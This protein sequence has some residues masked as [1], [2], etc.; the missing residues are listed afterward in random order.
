MERI[1]LLRLIRVLFYASAIVVFIVGCGC[2]DDD[3][4]AEDDASADRSDS[5]GTSGSGGIDGGGGESGT[6]SSMDSGAPDGA[7]V[8]GGNGGGGTGGRRLSR[9]AQTEPPLELGDECVPSTIVDVIG[10]CVAQ[11]DDCEGGTSIFDRTANCGDGLI[12][13]IR[14]DQCDAL[15]SAGETTRCVAADSCDQN[16]TEIT[17]GCPGGD[18]CCLENDFD[19]GGMPDFDFG[20]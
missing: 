1:E 15:E 4:G 7:T 12:C 6:S 3:D 13:C 16:E 20:T 17:F 19:D 8:S 10:E 18:V 5:G 9:D 11:D 2:D 14:T